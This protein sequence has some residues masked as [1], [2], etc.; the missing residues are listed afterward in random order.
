MIEWI[1]YAVLSGSIKRRTVHIKT[2]ER[3]PQDAIRIRSLLQVDNQV[4][5]ANEQRG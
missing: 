5:N 2:D 3:Q 1:V 4:H